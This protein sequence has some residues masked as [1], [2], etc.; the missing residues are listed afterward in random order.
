MNISVDTLRY[1]HL[2]IRG[3]KIVNFSAYPSRTRQTGGKSGDLGRF[4]G[5]SAGSSA[6]AVERCL[7]MGAFVV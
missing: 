2:V 4:G 5:T 3:S 6:S 7:G 1:N